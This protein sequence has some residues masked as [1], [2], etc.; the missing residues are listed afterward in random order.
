MAKGGPVYQARLQGLE[1][2]RDALIRYQQRDAEF[3]TSYW[4]PSPALQELFN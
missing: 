2:T 4:A 1:K 3:G